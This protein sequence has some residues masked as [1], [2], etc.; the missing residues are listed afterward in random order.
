MFVET[1]FIVIQAFARGKKLSPVLFAIYLN[2][3]QEYMAERSEGLPSLGC[4]AKGLGWEREDES[5]MLKHFILLY[6]DDTTKYYML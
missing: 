1:I 3:L 6:A 2:D 4:E 5:L